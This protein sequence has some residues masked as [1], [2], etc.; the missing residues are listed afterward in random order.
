MEKRKKY[1]A[2]ENQKALHK[3]K[4]FKGKFPGQVNE[5]K[6]IVEE[7]I[8]KFDNGNSGI[9]KDNEYKRGDHN[10]GHDHSHEHSHSQAKS[11]R[12]QQ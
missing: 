4:D 2:P 5:N 8:N 11:L 3:P 12:A 9:V 10:H 1:R 7:Q 6:Q